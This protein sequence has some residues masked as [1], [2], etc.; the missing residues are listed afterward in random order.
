[1]RYFF[2]FCDFV[3][4]WTLKRWTRPDM[5]KLLLL[6]P[7][8]EDFYDTDIRLQPI[9]L[10]YLK[11]A[12]KK[13][14]PE[15]QVTVR[16]YHRGR[17]RRTIPLPRELKYLREYYAVHD[18]G[19]FSSFFHYYRFGADYTEIAAEVAREQPDL[20]GISSLFSPYCREVVKTAEAIRRSWDGV[21]IAGG[22]HVSC[23]PES[24]LREGSID[25]IIRGEGERPLVEFLRQWLGD[26]DYGRVANLGYKAAG[27]TILNPLEENYPLDELPL[28]ETDDF[29]PEDY[30]YEN[31]PVCMVL[32]SRGCPHRCSFCSVHRT[33]GHRYR[34]RQPAEVFREMELRYQQGYRVFDFEDDNLTFDRKGFHELC[35]LITHHFAGREIELLAMNGVSHKSLDRETLDLMRRAGFTHLNLALVSAARE[36]LQAVNRPHLVDQFSRVVREAV[37]A[38]FAILAH[39]ILGLPGESLERMAETLALLAG[40]PLLIGVSIFYLTPGSPIAAQFPPMSAADLLRSRSTAMAI[41][42]P[43]CTRGDL[44]TLFITARI[45]N[46]LKGLD[47]DGE[48]AGFSELA[49]NFSGGNNR[50]AVGFRILTRLQREERLY[51]FNGGEFIHQPRF[52]SRLFFSVWNQIGTLTTQQGKRIHLLRHEAVETVQADNH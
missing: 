41:E 17:G 5:P 21:I 35:R 19:P 8:V 50:E 46:F 23:A 51:A 11:A 52:D 28:P 43:E 2:G 12:V 7:P 37:D 42:T 30:L 13:H 15:F 18:R 33:F 22:S 20:I 45:L 27:R 49:E 26:G 31:R 9:G 47:F 24:I 39:Q 40:Q 36:V 3:K 16:D 6:Q 34:R 14:L 44:F 48:E 1:L 10:C 4:R 38:G 29:Q 25:F 32:T